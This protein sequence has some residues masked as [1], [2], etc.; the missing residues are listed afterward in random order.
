MNDTKLNRSQ[1]YIQLVLEIYKRIPNSRK[2]TA[3]EIQQQLSEVGIVRSERTIQRNLTDIAQFFDDVDVDMRDKPFGYSRRSRHLLSHGPQEAVLL[4]LAENYLRYLLPVNLMKTLDTVFNDAKQHL[5]PT[6][7]NVKER[8]WLKKVRFVS[9]GVP[10]L[11]PHIDNEIFEKVSYALFHNRYLSLCY[12]NANLEQKSKEVMPL[13]L[14]Q[15]GSRLYLVCRFRGH[16]NERS[17]A[18]HR[19][20]KA[21][22]ST[23]DF[24]YPSDF[25]LERYDLDGRFYFGEGE[26]IRLSFCIGSESGYHLLETPLSIDQHV[27]LIDGGYQVTATVIDSLQLDRWLRGFGDEVWSITKEECTTKT[28]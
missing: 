6:T 15:Q 1:H 13:G 3:K 10:L 28:A 20:H 9:E 22:I 27:E 24:A 19:I 5:F 18:L 11:P 23:F 14:A 12:T 25:D 16:T 2:I 26:E 4:S 8:Q 21:S 17:L 7:S